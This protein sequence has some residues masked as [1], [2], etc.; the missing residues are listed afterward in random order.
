[1]KWTFEEDY[2]VGKF[3]LSHIDSW[4]V[5]INELMVLLKSAGFGSRDKGSVRMRLQNFE[6]IHSGGGLSNVAKQTHTIYA[7][8]VNQSGPQSN[9]A[10]LQAYINQYY[11][12]TSIDISDSVK[13]DLKQF[14]ALIEN[15]KIDMKALHLNYAKED[16]IRIIKQVFQMD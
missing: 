13:E 11:A 8:L 12:G 14:F 7:I 9:A 5:Q 6:H 1:M 16:A 15:E 3:Y 2:I 10:C 4:R